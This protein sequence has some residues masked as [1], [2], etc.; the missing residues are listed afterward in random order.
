MDRSQLRL[1]RFQLRLHRFQQR[2]KLMRN[3]SMFYF[4]MY[5][6]YVKLN[7]PFIHVLVFDTMWRTNPLQPSLGIK[8]DRLLM[9]C[10]H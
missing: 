3:V 6:S 4:F 10:I 5:L 2:I 1:N 9:Y 7:S 8:D